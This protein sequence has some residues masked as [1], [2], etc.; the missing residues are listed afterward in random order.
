MSQ[1]IVLNDSLLFCLV[2]VT[3]KAFLLVASLQFCIDDE[4]QRLR[5]C[6]SSRVILGIC[7]AACNLVY[8]QRR[9]MRHAATS[10]LLY[11]GFTAH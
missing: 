6:T 9:H 4:L 1:K 7:D 5:P 2:R 11:D 8:Q 3:L 10:L